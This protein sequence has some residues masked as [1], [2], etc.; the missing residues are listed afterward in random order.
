M[1]PETMS[2]SDLK[3]YVYQPLPTGRSIRLFRTYGKDEKGRIRG[4]LKIVDLDDKPKYHCLSY[5]WMCPPTD[6]ILPEEISQLKSTEQVNDDPIPIV[7]D[8]Q[9]INIHSNLHN[10]LSNVPTDIWYNR[11]N[12]KGRLG[13]TPLIW[14]SMSS[15]DSLVRECLHAGA[16]VN[17]RD[18]YGRTGLHYAANQGF[19]DIVRTLISAGVDISV[20]DTT[21]KTAFE[22]AAQYQEAEICQYLENPP[23]QEEVPLGPCLESPAHWIWIDALCIDQGNVTERTS[24]VKMMDLIFQRAVFTIAWLG[25]ENHHTAAAAR[26]IKSIAAATDQ[27]FLQSDIIPFHEQEPAVYERAGISYISFDD[28]K[29]L[30]A[31][32]LRRWL[33]RSWVIQEVVLSR[34]LLVFCG[35]HE[36]LFTEL[37]RV[38]NLIKMR[39]SILKRRTSLQFV[40]LDS[41]AVPVETNLCDLVKYREA[42]LEDKPETLAQ[43]S[44]MRLLIDTWTFHATDPRDKIYSLY[45]LLSL[46][47]GSNPTW[48]PDYAK[49]VARCFADATRVLM[50]EEGDMNVLC[51]VQDH[52]V[53]TTP[54]LPSWVPDYAMPYMNM[55]T[56]YYTAAKGLP[57]TLLPS[58]NWDTLPIRAVKLDTITQIGNDRKK[59]PN[60]MLHFDPSWFELISELNTPYRTGEYPTEVFW[61]T[62]CANQNMQHQSPAPDEYG[63]LFREMVS[64]MVWAAIKEDEKQAMAARAQKAADQ[65]PDAELTDALAQAYLQDEPT[66]THVPQGE[67]LKKALRLLYIFAK[68]EPRSFT[69][70]HEELEEFCKKPVRGEQTF[71]TAVKMRYGSRRLYVTAGRLLGLGPISLNVGDSV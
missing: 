45:G 11:N 37:G 21:G 39:D 64:E 23:S 10:T 53:Q 34:D 70:N 48:A 44:F 60:S 61:R 26:T 9:I 46:P 32:L 42:Y 69:P 22:Y 62:L 1:Q 16:D 2:S 47:K 20:I 43:F 17:A 52:S 40:P 67:G 6:G 59:V 13:R 4:T 65:D 49:S 8:D 68:S 63:P 50:E 15:D 66:R 58:K 51:T 55:M 5:T 30:A 29:S 41:I 28:W 38:A 25:S 3:P 35:S 71:V 54:G 27:Q 14:S 56:G 24:Q 33:R 57:F 36:I 7:C 19:F 31:L 12:R 18:D